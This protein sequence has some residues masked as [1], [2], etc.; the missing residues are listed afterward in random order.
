[1]NFRGE[2]MNKIVKFPIRSERLQSAELDAGRIKATMRPQRLTLFG[3]LAWLWR[4]L[5]LPL[6]LVLYWL[7]P[8]IMA[9]CSLVSTPALLCFIA[10]FFF[11]AGESPHRAIVWVFGGVSFTAFALGWFYDSLLLALAPD[12]LVIGL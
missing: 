6:F 12:G 4:L 1:M 8:L 7:R 10:S 2:A 11:I 9:V 3:L 5:R